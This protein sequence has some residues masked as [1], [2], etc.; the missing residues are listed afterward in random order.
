MAQLAAFNRACRS[1]RDGRIHSRP[2]VSVASIPAFRQL[3]DAF[4]APTPHMRDILVQRLPRTG[5]AGL[6]A[7]EQG[8]FCDGSGHQIGFGPRLAMAGHLD[9][10]DSCHCAQGTSVHVRLTSSVCCLDMS[11]HVINLTTQASA[12]NLSPHRH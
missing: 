9:S 8:D 4:E 10:K 2:R 12:L 6:V 7:R 11:L 5:S 3:F 1:C